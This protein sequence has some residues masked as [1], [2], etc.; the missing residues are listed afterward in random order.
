MC[1]SHGMIQSRRGNNSWG[2][3]QKNIFEVL[4]GRAL[5]FSDLNETCILQCMD[6]IFCEE[7]QR[8]PLKFH[9]KYF[10]HTM[11]DMSYIQHSNV[12]SS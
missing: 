10:T 7:F 9:T 5:K 3:F 12:K 4:N 11:K 6:N 1:Y 8:E 2:P